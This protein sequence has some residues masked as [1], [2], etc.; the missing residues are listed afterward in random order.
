M[1]VLWP[2]AVGLASE[3]QVQIW[4]PGR[5]SVLDGCL[6]QPALVCSNGSSA[7]ALVHWVPTCNQIYGST[8]AAA[9]VEANAAAAAAAATVRKQE[10]TMNRSLGVQCGAG[11]S[12]SS[13]TSISHPHQQRQHVWA[14]VEKRH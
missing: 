11:C 1:R 14:C 7:A 3:A 6:W 2:G 13:G 12:T 10:S 8:V 5:S 9:A 4:G